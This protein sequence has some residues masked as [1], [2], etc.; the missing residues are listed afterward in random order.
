MERSSAWLTHLGAALLLALTLWS[1]RTILGPV[2]ATGALC[3]LL[4]PYRA[5]DAVRRLLLVIV[6]LTLMWILSQ[7]RSV[8]YPALLAL[9]LAFL[10]NPLVTRLARLR[11]RR[12]LASLM[13]IFPLVALLLLFFLVILPALLEQAR[14]LTERLPDAYRKLVEWLEPQLQHLLAGEGPILPGDLAGLLPTGE[15]VL[16]GM[17]TGLVQVG[18]GVAAVIRVA[19]FLVLTPIFTYYILVDFNR[20]QD[21]VRPYVPPV[22]RARLRLLGSRF[23]ESVGAWLRG[24]LIVAAIMAFL[25]LG[26]FLLIGLPYALLL[27][28]AA[29]L[30]NLVPVL[31]FWITAILSLI[32]CLFTPDPGPMLLRTAA[33]LLVAQVL[34]QNALSPLFVGRQLHVKPVVLLLVML[35]MGSLLGIAG[36]LLAAPAIGLAHGL[37]AML[38]LGRRIPAAADAA[39]P[40]T[41]TG[42]GV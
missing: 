26:G 27:G 30:L 22:W 18:K 1:L 12:S 32:S 13:V 9:A 5:H 35:G 4:W 39:P 36:L 3:F 6:L 31:G 8:V 14:N 16:R 25:T 21:T 23:Q 38:D 24:Q 11:V 2:V 29:G 15:Q 7:A 37:W 34:E 33:V 20:L 42:P 19:T 40:A 28:F 10:L 17:T 41:E